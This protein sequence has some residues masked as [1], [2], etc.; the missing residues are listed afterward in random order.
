MRPHKQHVMARC[1]AGVLVL[2]L[3]SLGACSVI[4]DGLPA[5]AEHDLGPVAPDQSFQPRD[6]PVHLARVTTAND[7]AG[8]D[9]LYRRT[10]RDP[11]QVHRYAQHV[12]RV[13]P[14]LLI[15]DRLSQLGLSARA[16]AE[17]P[18]QLVL[19]LVNF[20]QVITSPTDAHVNVRVDAQL[21]NAQGALVASYRFIDRSPATA[22]L[23]GALSGLTAAARR[24]ADNINQWVFDA[25]AR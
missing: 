15:A 8:T 22:D 1:G 10:D 9:I 2:V 23:A 24:Q 13:A 25:L 18:Y 5:L 7:L 12:W 6:L 20:E 19:R 14:V 4:P 17:T 21:R 16:T 11:T 3:L